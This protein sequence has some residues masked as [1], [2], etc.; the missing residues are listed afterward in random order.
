MYKN[1]EAA[2]ALRQSAD[3]RI[4]SLPG[5]TFEAYEVTSGFGHI[6]GL[7]GNEDGNDDS[8]GGG[9]WISRDLAESLGLARGSTVRAEGL[10]TR[11][12]GVF[13]YPNDGRY[14]RLSHA[15]LV[16]VPRGA[17]AF[18]ECWMSTWPQSPDAGGILRSVVI[19]AQGSEIAVSQL[20][21]S[22]AA[23]FEADASFAERQTRWAPLVTVSGGF[24]LGLAWARRRKLEYASSLHAGQSRAALTTGVVLETLVW[25]LLGAV[26][27]G[28]A[29]WW[30]ALTLMPEEVDWLLP[31]LVPPVLSAA[32]GAV[33]GSLSGALWMRE[34]DLFRYFKER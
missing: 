11:V 19:P 1:V 14:A 34:S 24:L 18:D 27:A 6:L 26:L 30:A 10:P 4:D 3:V 28:I 9:V 17:G 8:N 5:T 29:M 23:H 7:N 13:D 12:A 16:P 32:V 25:A 2:G 22:L 21:R 31:L 33:I 15:I 20:N